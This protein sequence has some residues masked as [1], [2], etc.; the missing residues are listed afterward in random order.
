[1]ILILGIVIGVVV[2]GVGVWFLVLGNGDEGLAAGKTSAQQ[3]E[4]EERKLEI[5]RLMGE[6]GQISNDE[7]EKALGVSDASATRYL[8][9]LE[10][11]GRIRQVGKTG[12]FVTYTLT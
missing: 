10:R 2:G 5:L 6:K 1:M 8:D 12:R 11:E 9:E 4:K 7:V 3:R